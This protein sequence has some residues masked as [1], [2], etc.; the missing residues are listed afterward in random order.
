MKG[1]QAAKLTTMVKFPMHGFDMSPH[2]AKP[3]SNNGGSSVGSS[4]G[5]SDCK[6][7]LYAVCYH[8]GN[9]LETGHYTAACLNPYD[10]EWYRYDDQRVSQV[11]KER[12]EEEIINDEA[13]M[14]FYQKRKVDSDGSECSG[15]S[16]GS[17]GEHWISRIAPPPKGE[18]TKTTIILPKTV[19]EKAKEEEDAVECPVAEE[20]VVVV[21]EEAEEGNVIVPEII[22]KEGIVP[23]AE[24]ERMVIE[25]EEETITTEELEPVKCPKV[26]ESELEKLKLDKENGKSPEIKLKEEQSKESEI[27]LNPE[28][29]RDSTLEIISQKESKEDVMKINENPS[30]T[31]ETKI[32]TTESVSELKI[33]EEKETISSI[34][35]ALT[36]TESKQ[37][38]DNDDSLVVVRKSS[39]IPIQRSSAPLDWSKAFD[40][41][42][43]SSRH[44]SLS[45]YSNGQV[46]GKGRDQLDSAVS[47]LRASS[48]CSKDRFLFM[49]HHRHN[50]HNHHRSITGRNLIDEDDHRVLGNNNNHSLWV[51][52]GHQKKF[53][54]MEY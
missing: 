20:V 19:V 14:L 42:L 23:M 25:E 43:N 1:P 30:P 47:L 38:L 54:G 34:K 24:E 39:P 41:S 10:Q 27:K 36:E 46:N 52:N 8:Q 45:C 15:S 16:T 33:V 21:A 29:E 26:D 37:P 7:D 40:D 28:S 5:S 49:D 53:W 2:L 31:E 17:S 48:A 22:I 35:E 51:S 11:P 13:Y 4:I 50:R 12:V 3:E 32:T 44:S 18:L 9:T 6:Y